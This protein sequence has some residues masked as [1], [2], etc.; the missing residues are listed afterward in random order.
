MSSQSDHWTKGS[1]HWDFLFKGSF[2]RGEV[3]VEVAQLLPQVVA[4]TL[5]RTG[6]KSSTFRSKGKLTDQYTMIASTAHI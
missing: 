4:G 6:F 5:T 2:Q 3:R 1:L